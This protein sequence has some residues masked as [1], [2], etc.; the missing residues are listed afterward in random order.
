[1]FFKKII[2]FILRTSACFFIVKKRVHKEVNSPGPRLIG[3]YL[4]NGCIASQISSNTRVYGFSIGTEMATLPPVAIKRRGI[5][6]RLFFKTIKMVGI[7]SCQNPYIEIAP[8]NDFVKKNI[9]NNESL[10]QDL[11][12]LFYGRTK[13]WFRVKWLFSV[14]GRLWAE[15]D[16]RIISFQSHIPEDMA[17]ISKKI[18]KI[19]QALKYGTKK[20]RQTWCPIRLM[21]INGFVNGLCLW[22]LIEFIW[23]ILY[24]GAFQHANLL[25]LHGLI[26]DALMTTAIVLVSLFVW[27]WI[28]ANDFFTRVFALKYNFVKTI[29]SVFAITCFVLHDIN[30][31]PDFNDSTLYKGQIIHK[32][33]HRSTKGGTSYHVE[34]SIPGLNDS[35]SYSSLFRG[36]YDMVQKGDRVQVVIREGVLGYP[37]WDKKIVLHT[38]DA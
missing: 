24:R 10:L 8:M 29:L 31:D 12:D 30:C 18:S 20:Q 17:N 3:R 33:K 19:R 11:K 38:K 23:I 32:Y 22:A 25:S 37:W 36:T 2:Y 27:R 6:G 4:P 9:L 26:H 13:S 7:K 14:K 21:K 28:V 16:I 35:L 5:L 1:M 15:T 34:I